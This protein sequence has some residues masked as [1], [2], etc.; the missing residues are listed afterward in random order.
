MKQSSILPIIPPTELL[1]YYPAIIAFLFLSLVLNAAPTKLFETPGDEESW[2]TQTGY[3]LR[4]T[5]KSADHGPDGKKCT[6]FRIEF[7][8]P[9]LR[10]GDSRWFNL[11]K[12]ITPDSSW[13]NAESIGFEL[14]S[15]QKTGWYVSWE[16]IEEDGT[17]FAPKMIPFHS[18]PERFTKYKYKFSDL[19]CKEDGNRKIHPEAERFPGPFSSATLNCWKKRRRKRNHFSRS[20]SRE[21]VILPT[22]WTPGIMSICALFSEKDLKP[23][24]RSF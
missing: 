23:C 17:K 20:G 8:D 7:K 6:S 19:I 1:K 18:L 15:N 14:A 21:H 11:T 22:H 16:L 4:T 10:K 2:E 13:K 24:R 5:V 3:N 12:A 9:S